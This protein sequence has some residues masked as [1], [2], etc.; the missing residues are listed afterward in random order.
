MTATGIAFA[1]QYL[2]KHFGL[3]ELRNYLTLAA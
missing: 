2:A 3:T 1:L